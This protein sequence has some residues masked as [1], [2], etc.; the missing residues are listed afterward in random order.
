[1]PPVDFW[2]VCLVLAMEQIMCDFEGSADT[3]IDLRAKKAIAWKII[4]DYTRKQSEKGN[5][6][7]RRSLYVVVDVKAGD[8]VTP[9]NVRSIRPG[10][11]LAPRHYDDIIGRR[12]ASDVARA[13]PVS[14][15]LLDDVDNDRS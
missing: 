12:F 14:W 7:F 6:Q 11:G 1:M 15:D 13:T 5:A 9:D 8:T 2:T 3:N 4:L 10:F